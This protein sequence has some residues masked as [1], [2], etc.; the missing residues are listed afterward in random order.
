MLEQIVA[1]LSLREASLKGEE[2]WFGIL[3]QESSQPAYNT[4]DESGYKY[5]ILIR[6]LVIPLITQ[7]V[8]Y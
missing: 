1:L 2:E 7:R 3:G 5:P 6:L 8:T 4:T